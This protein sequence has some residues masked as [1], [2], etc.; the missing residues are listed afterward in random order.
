[1]REEKEKERQELNRIKEIER[2]KRL[3]EE[4]KIREIAQES[5]NMKNKD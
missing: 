1:M 3:D 5:S 2:Q 4:G